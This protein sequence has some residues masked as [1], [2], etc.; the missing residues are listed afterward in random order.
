MHTTRLETLAKK[1]QPLL[2]STVTSI[3]MLVPVILNLKMDDH[4]N[5]NMK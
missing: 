4:A 3:I 1:R 2:F 5:L